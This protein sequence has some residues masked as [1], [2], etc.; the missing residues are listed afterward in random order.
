ML[1]SLHSTI[2]PCGLSCGTC[3]PRPF[4]PSFE[5]DETLCGFPGSAWDHQDRGAA[6]EPFTGKRTVNDYKI[7]VKLKQNP[8]YLEGAQMGVKRR[9]RRVGTHGFQQNTNVLT[10]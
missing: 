4:S 10:A 3:P 6:R 1:I 9:L 8:R 5:E 7:Q 2:S